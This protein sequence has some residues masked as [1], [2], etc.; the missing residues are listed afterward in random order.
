MRGV[1]L[2]E[3]HQERRLV[4]C[5]FI[6][7]VGS[8][9]MTMRLGPERLKNALDAAF[10]E[11]R[12]LIIAQGGTV[13]KY[14]GDAIYALFG[15]PVSHADDPARALRVASAC[16]RWARDRDPG[17][18]PFVVRVGV[19]TGEAIVDL[20]ASETTMQQMSVGAVVNIAARLQQRADPGQALVG[21]NC[22]AAAADTAELVALGEIEL[23]GV[24]KLPAWSLVDIVDAAPS[25]RLP[26]VGR[27]AELKLLGYALQRAVS[28]RSVLALVSGP[29][30]Q[31]KTRL[32]TEFVSQLDPTI[33]LMTARCRPE[34]ENGALTPLRQL[35]GDHVEEQLAELFPDQAERERVG[36]AL[37]HSAGLEADDALSA[38]TLTERADEIANAW[39][40]YLGTLA[41]DGAIVAWIEDV[42]WA[43]PAVVRLIDRISKG[44]DRL[45]FVAT[46]RPE[47]SETAGLRPSGDRFFIELE[48]LERDAAS[49]LAR[50]AGS[51]DL[52]A[53]GRADGNPLFI[54][55]LARG[56]AAGGDQTLSL[57]LQGALGARLDE[58]VPADRSLLAHAAVVG[59]TFSVEDA[60]VL[61]KTDPPSAGRVLAR[62][63]DLQYVDQVPG[64]YRFHHS[65]VRDVAYGRLLVAERMRLHA[66]YARERANPEDAEVLAHHWWEALR[67]PD[68]EWVW[69]GEPGLADMRREAF[70]AHLAA[71]SDARHFAGTRA[72]EL[73]ERAIALAADGR[74]RGDAERALGDAHAI[75]FRADDAWAHYLRAREAY[76]ADGAVPA[77]LYRGMFDIRLKAQAFHVPPDPVF[78]DELLAEAELGARD[79]GDKSALA[80]V[81]LHR[82]LVPGELDD[83]DRLREAHRMAAESG[84]R[85]IQIETLGW[86]VMAMLDRCDVDSAGSLLDEADR[87]RAQSAGP[88]AAPLDTLESRFTVALLRGD[89]A[90]AE[91]QADRGVALSA[92]MGPHLRTHAIMPRSVVALARGDWDV[93]RTLGHE[94]Q[95]IMAAN[96]S[97]PFCRYAAVALANGAIGAALEHRPDDALAL[98]RL[99]NGVSGA[100]GDVEILT[101][102]PRVMLGDRFDIPA[103]SQAWWYLDVYRAITMSHLHQRAGLREMETRFRTLGAN[104][105]RSLVALADALE[106][107]L[108]ATAGGPRA[109]HAGLRALGC[110][111]WSSLL[112]PGAGVQREG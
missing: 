12:G 47:F 40:R 82:A 4:T 60:A 24:G 86:L 99:A 108:A 15:A 112:V 59:E 105:S 29:P 25:V 64:G 34:G 109:S 65:L 68:A 52:V 77:A 103:S 62:L 91:A 9:E 78:V 83:V 11:L 31:G 81:F 61:V 63:A 98:L 26:F 53:L 41:G 49:S 16:L 89:L 28:G 3:R 54:V 73:L 88:I 32:V 94:T 69:Q 1:T 55:E 8:T 97:T 33:R 43:D 21:P 10:S 19:E 75:D 45:L 36:A 84:D 23:K 51:A 7:V 44:S 14:I 106:E 67:P 71:G 22:H 79:T 37:L 93:V 74:A 70:A 100:K 38:L 39:R 6:D 30:G 76:R 17:Q 101:A 104:G 2:I 42:H 66:R 72:V 80:R 13:E 48:G 58:L 56:R 87:L 96:P 111:G 50:S 107:L 35:V 18:V 110:F 57:T 27:Q 95:G 46:A 20:A 85:A 5:L 102:L 92:P 90:E